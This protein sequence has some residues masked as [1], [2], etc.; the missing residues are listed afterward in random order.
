MK[1]IIALV[2]GIGLVVSVLGAQELGVGFARALSAGEREMDGVAVSARLVS[3]LGES[4]Y[5]INSSEGETAYVTAE[6]GRVSKVD[7]PEDAAYGRGR[8][9]GRMGD[10]GAMLEAVDATIEWQRIIDAASAAADRE[11]IHA[12]G[13]RFAGGRLATH[14]AFGSPFEEDGTRVIVAVDPE[15]FTVIESF[16]GRE[17]PDRRGDFRPGARRGPG[18]DDPRAP[19]GLRGGRR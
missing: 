15:S 1:R 12:V 6:S 11:D 3:V 2:V 7:E 4:V 13:L 14:V 9:H 17:Q 19:G 16:E 10:L 8:G 5:V 18:A